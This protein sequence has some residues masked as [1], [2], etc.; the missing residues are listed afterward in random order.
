MAIRKRFDRDLYRKYD[1]LAKT[2]TELFYSKLGFDVREHDNRYAQD[3]VV[4]G[5]LEGHLA[6]CEVKLVWDGDE[7]PYDS[8]QLPERKK[9]FFNE[10]TRFF[11]WNKTLTRAATFWSTDIE[12]LEP[13]EVPNKYVY[14]GEYFFQ[15]PLDKVDFVALKHN[16]EL[17]Q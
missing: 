7:F 1:T 14:K 10:K 2:A 11:I 12:D 5:E 3:L 13:V 8:V 15:I 17:P 6:E 16:L 9:K 4:Q